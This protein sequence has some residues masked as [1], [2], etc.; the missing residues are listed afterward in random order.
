MGVNKAFER[1]REAV[2]FVLSLALFGPVWAGA[3][4]QACGAA[5]FADFVVAFSDS[6]LLQRGN[7]NNPLHWQHMDLKA[8]PEPRPVLQ[9]LDIDQVAF[10]VMPSAARRQ[11]ASLVLTIDAPSEYLGK[12]TLRKADTDFLVNYYFIKRT[13]WSLVR[14]DDWSL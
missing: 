10:P 12:V 3:E 13:C 4:G 2:V 1:I 8:Q 14:I 7:T 11:Q 6:A 5:S 9:S